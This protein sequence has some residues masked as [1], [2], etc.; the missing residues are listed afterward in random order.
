MILKDREVRCRDPAGYVGVSLNQVV[1]E[2]IAFLYISGK[3]GKR[4]RSTLIHIKWYQS[5]I[6]FVYC[7]QKRKKEDRVAEDSVKDLFAGRK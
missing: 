3:R 1:S 4:N 6:L 5:K 7:R 2:P